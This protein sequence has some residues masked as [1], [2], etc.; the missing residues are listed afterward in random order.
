MD[1]MIHRASQHDAPILAV[2]HIR[3][4]LGELWASILDRGCQSGAQHAR[5]IHNLGT[6]SEIA[7]CGEIFT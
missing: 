2:P 4:I 1:A 6:G 3:Q 7:T 5:T